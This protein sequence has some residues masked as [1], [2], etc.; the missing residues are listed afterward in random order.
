MANS[1]SRHGV[2]LDSVTLGA[3]TKLGSRLQAELDRTRTTGSIY[4]KHVA[5]KSLSPEMEIETFALQ[6]WLDEVWITGKTIESGGTLVAYFQKFTEDSGPAS[7]NHRSL[8]VTKG[9]M[10]PEKISVDHQG[11][12][13]LSYKVLVAYD[14]T[15][16]PIIVSDAASLPASPSDNERFTIGIC[17]VGGVTV[18]Q[19]TKIEIDFGIM[20]KL[21]GEDSSIYP[22][23]AELR[24]VEPTISITT[25]NATLMKAAGIPL[26]GL[27]CTHANT[28]VVLRKR[29]QDA[30]HFV[31]SGTS[32]H[33]KFT[34]Y[35]IATIDTPD[36]QS[37]DDP[38]TTTFK[39]TCAHDGTNTPLVVDTTATNT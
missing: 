32:E 38:A 37:G 17:T 4:S 26:A 22:T 31:A 36:E 27:A 20:A 23:R 15:N 30:N 12:A 9:L 24:G 14:G 1:Y 28:K 13:T 35:G 8:T 21:L 34:A 11:D 18:D 33:I 10:V 29:S 16:A 25:R 5:L 19:I 39:I 7:S 3:I 6:D 2:V